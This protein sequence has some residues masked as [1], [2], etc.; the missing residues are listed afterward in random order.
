MGWAYLRDWRGE[1][2]WVVGEDAKSDWELKK[3]DGKEQPLKKEWSQSL[4][5]MMKKKRLTKL[6]KS[7][8]KNGNESRS[9]EL[10]DDCLM[11]EW[12]LGE[13]IH[14]LHLCGKHQFH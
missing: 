3:G 6:K 13:E 7:K 2:G 4:K 14:D 5:K 9:A 11:D 10:M 1:R 12:M 8:K